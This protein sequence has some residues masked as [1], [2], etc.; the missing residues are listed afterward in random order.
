MVRLWFERGDARGAVESES[1]RLLRVDARVRWR[2]RVRCL[3]YRKLAG[4]R[5]TT[6]QISRG[7][8]ATSFARYRIRIPLLYT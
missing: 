3:L 4:H 1:E 6:Q 5:I 7:P 8:V 2:V